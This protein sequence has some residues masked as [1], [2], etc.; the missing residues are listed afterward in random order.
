MASPSKHN[1]AEK[2]PASEQSYMQSLGS[3]VSS[4]LPAS[5]KKQQTED[6]KDKILRVAF[7]TY[8]IKE[9]RHHTLNLSM[10]NG[11]QVW[12]VTDPDDTFELVS[13]REGPIKLIKF[14]QQP[15][16][17]GRLS[18]H[19]PVIALASAR[20]DEASKFPL[21]VVKLYSLRSQE[22]INTMRFRSEVYDVRCSK[23]VLIV[24]LRDHIYGFDLL[25]MT[26]KVLSIPCFPQDPPVSSYLV[27]PPGTEFFSVTSCAL[28]LGPRWIAYP[29][30]EPMQ[31]GSGEATGPGAID[32]IVEMAKYLGDVGMKTMSSYMYAESPEITGERDRER[33]RDREREREKDNGAGG[34]V[35]I[36][37]V[38]TGTPIAHFRAHRQPIGFMAF[39][40][41]GT[42]LVTASIG[43]QNFNVFQIAAKRSSSIY[44]IHTQI[45][46]LVRGRTAGVVTD[47]SFSSDSRWMAVSTARGTTHVYAM[48][49]EGGPVNIH[50]HIPSE[51]VP[52]FELPFLY[53]QSATKLIELQVSDRIR[54]DIPTDLDETGR[55]PFTAASFR[56]VGGGASSLK[57]LMITQL[58]LLSEHILRPHPPTTPDVDSRTLFLDIAPSFVWDVSRKTNVAQSLPRFRPRKQQSVDMRDSKY[59]DKAEPH[60]L[61]HVE[62]CTHIHY[63][64]L[65]AGPQFTFK[66]FQK[67]PLAHSGDAIMNETKISVRYNS[68]VTPSR[69]VPTLR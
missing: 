41:S 61:S 18:G 69:K 60:W 6:S 29:S 64:P 50:T 58:G 54:Q 35:I 27:R 10:T 37:D 20:D 3:M 5:F 23:K 22:Y 36:A 65:C 66:T 13:R 12:D 39:D 11:F 51:P 44:D 53:T 57:V 24:A 21:S 55:V 4:I 52:N 67:R 28:A 45:Y 1:T 14:V 56:L 48:N 30:S 32:N 34:T 8:E 63:R 47:I 43:G 59:T 9:E 33:D 25:T 7:D 46:R 15:V 40:P 19:Y 26:A 2:R 42:L 49:L 68:T 17:Q 31:N 62:I 16:G 38:A